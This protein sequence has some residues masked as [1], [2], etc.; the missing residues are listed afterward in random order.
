[1]KFD[2]I[3]RKVDVGL[4]DLLLMLGVVLL[5][6]VL[7]TMAYFTLTAIAMMAEGSEFKPTLNDMGFFL[8]GGEA[9]FKSVLPVISS[10]IALALAKKKD[11]GYCRSMA[12]SYFILISISLLLSFLGTATDPYRT[13]GLP[14]LVLWNIALIFT[15]ATLSVMFYL[16]L[17]FFL[18]IDWKQVKL[19]V[20][21][22]ALF[23]VVFF[24]IGPIS[25]YL[26]DLLVEQN[27][28]W[29]FELGQANLFTLFT[30]FLVAFP[31]LYHSLG[32]KIERQDI[33]LLIGLVLGENLFRM[34]VDMFSI[35]SA[36]A[37]FMNLVY[38]LSI[39]AVSRINLK[40]YF[41]NKN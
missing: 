10:I 14:T 39:Y 29:A 25:T 32:K 23:A 41:E 2:I 9:L 5:T 4:N 35:A 26:Y 37:A 20:M 30:D 12:A 21:S 22:A 1:M 6:G 17:L 27:I 34:S 33:L 16:W 18:N 11:V 19:G 7:T 13:V 3:G 31:L 24:L 8:I 40:S 38:F 36:T 28:W 15:S